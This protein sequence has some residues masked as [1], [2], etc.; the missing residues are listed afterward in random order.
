[1]NLKISPIGTTEVAQSATLNLSAIFEGFEAAIIQQDIEWNLLTPTTGSESSGTVC[2][3]STATTGYGVTLAQSEQIILFDTT[4]SVQ[5]NAPTMAHRFGLASGNPDGSNHNRFTFR[6]LP[7][8]GVEIMVN[9]QVITTTSTGLTSP[10]S[11]VAGQP[12]KIEIRDRVISWL[13]NDVIVHQEGPDVGNECWY[14]ASAD[15]SAPGQC[16]SGCKIESAIT[17]TIQRFDCISWSVSG[18]VLTQSRGGETAWVAPQ[19]AGTYTITA[20]AEG[21]GSDTLTVTVG[22]IVFGNAVCG[23]TVAAGSLVE[24]TANGGTGATLTA[25]GGTVI[26]ATHWLAPSEPNTYNLTYTNNGGSTACQITVVP[27]LEIEGVSAGI[28]D[29]I[30]AGQCHQFVSTLP[31]TSYSST[32]GADRISSAGFFCAPD[33]ADGDNFGSHTYTVTAVNGNQSVTFQIVLDPV[34]PTP[35]VTGPIPVKWLPMTPK[36]ATR[37]QAND[38]L[39]RQYTTLSSNPERKWSLEYKMLPQ[40]KL[41]TEDDSACITT[42]LPATVKLPANHYAGRL[43]AFY[44]LVNG[45]GLPFWFRDRD[46]K[47]HKYAHFASFSRDHASDDYEGNQSRK[48]EILVSPCCDPVELSS[49]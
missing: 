12:C 33:D 46:G 44:D 13:I 9:E 31:G 21:V 29:S 32:D 34:Y 49:C 7:P 10:L 43:D 48:V 26:D 47:M 17:G 1:M 24:F 19:L 40:C 2:K 6:F 45:E 11:V 18:G 28:F 16:L 36:Y 14:R 23:G 37:S 30:F 42:S 3:N 22:N 15:L 5:C 27:A 8:G 25:D 35:D 4:G 20:S 38:L 41:D 39:C